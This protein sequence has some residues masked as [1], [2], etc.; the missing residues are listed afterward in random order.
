MKEKKKFAL[1]VSLVC[2]SRSCLCVIKPIEWMSM[3]W[4]NEFS[5]IFCIKLSAMFVVLAIFC[6]KYSWI[7]VLSLF[8]LIIFFFGFCVFI[9]AV[10]TNSH[11]FAMSRDHNIWRN[12]NYSAK[13]I[14]IVVFKFGGEKKMVLFAVGK[15]NIA[16][17]RQIFRVLS[18]P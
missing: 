5:W 4:R 17:T 12:E 18:F 13:C 9:S 3:T 8:R 1:N 2:M 11:S 10:D 16:Y 14:G 15:I 6:Y 7:D